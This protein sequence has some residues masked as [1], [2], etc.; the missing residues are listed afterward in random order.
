MLK[1]PNIALNFVLK[2]PN[3][4]CPEGRFGTISHLQKLA[5]GRD[6][7]EARSKLMHR[8]EPHLQPRGDVASMVATRG[9][10]KLIGDAGTGINDEQVA[11]RLNLLCADHSSQAIEAERLRR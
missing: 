2:P 1:G 7:R 10:N 8:F 5:F 3:C 6:E 11:T 4:T 9:I